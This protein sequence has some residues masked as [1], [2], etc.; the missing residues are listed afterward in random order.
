M[1]HSAVLITLLVCVSSHAE[2]RFETGQAARALIGQSTF[3]DQKP[4]ATAELIG[5]ISGIAVANNTLF[6]ADA[7]RIGATPLNHR[8]LIYN[9]V[10]SFLPGKTDELYFTKPCPVCNGQANVVLGQPDFTTTELGLAQ[11]KLRLPT[12]V[13]SDGR[14]LAVADTDNNRVLIWNSIPTTNQANADVVVGQPDFSK[15]SI[16][17]NNRPTAQSMRGPQGVWIHDGKLYVADTQ[18]HRVLIWN[19]IPTSNG[20]AADIVLGQPDFTSF[21]EPDL[22]RAENNA[23]ANNMLNPVSVTTDGVR[24]Y[25]ADLGYNRVLVWNSIPTRNQ[26]PADFALGQPDLTSSLSNNSSKLCESNGTDDD[27]NPTYPRRCLATMDFP[28]FALSDGNRLF[29]ADGGNDRVLIYDTPPTHNGETP[30]WVIGQLGGQINQAS[31]STD[32]MRTPMSLAWDGTNLYVSDTYNRRIMIYSIAEPNVPYT[33]VRNA[34]SL[35]IYAVGGLTF[36]G[37]LKE[38]DE[39]TI[40]IGPTDNEKEY[41]YKIVKDET[42]DT[43]INSI[44]NLINADAGDPYVLATPNTVA[45][46]IVLTSRLPGSDGNNTNYSVE[47][48]DS[49]V[50]TVATAG[51]S[52]SGGED[53][54]RIA[55]G[56]DVSILGDNLASRIEEVNP[57]L[58]ILPATLADTQVYFDGI[59]APLFYVSPTQ[60]NAQIP[61]EVRD[62]TST[63]IWVR[64]KRPDGTIMVTVPRAVTIVPQN[65]GIFTNP[66]PEPRPAV[67]LH[68]S[69]YA[70]GTVSVDG[71]PTAGEITIVTIEDR[72]YKY[73]IVPG[74]TLASVRDKLVE[75]I[76]QDPRVIATP[77]GTFTRIRLRARIEGPEGI[78]IPYNARATTSSGG[79]GAS[80]IMTA[81][82]SALCCANTGLVTEGNPAV[83]G[84]TIIIYATG[85]GLS[86]PRTEVT[87]VKYNGPVTDPQEFVNSLAGGKTANVLLATMKQG[88]IGVYE[89]HL[90]LNS[91]LPTNPFTQLTIAQDLY[92]SNIVTFPLFNPLPS[93]SP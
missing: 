78:G 10:N 27:G 25:V 44:V 7:N 48:S 51:A 5:S 61:F 12:A 66:G 37:E 69:P 36:G 40:K 42:F 93:G 68:G 64:S 73:T 87:G 90:E 8:V 84:E 79:D 92:V 89:L 71:S 17:P 16:P 41:K 9:N 22:T 21:V 63:N 2:E 34:A 81:F 31:D 18:N 47:T 15:A 55:P 3:T 1:K 23:T 91:D 50:V 88:E 70:T 67:M 49:A 32:S 60:I 75:L 24:L 59:A 80:V 86:E 52:L 35:E 65:P 14:Y 11:N 39:I 85:L 43:L 6:V 53:A 33:G 4:G 28:R 20:Q 76:N 57:S 56:T 77:S 13:A 58:D 30:S 54:A 45:R 19:R 29:V 46:A 74:D 82:G 72:E 26:Q 62:R 38:N 83:P